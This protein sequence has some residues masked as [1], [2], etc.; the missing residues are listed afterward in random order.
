MR[1][2]PRDGWRALLPLAGVKDG[3]ADDLIALVA[4]DHVV[5]CDLAVGGMTG[6]LE[7]DVEGVRLFV[8]GRPEIAVRR[9]PDDGSELQ[10]LLRVY[11]GRSIMAIAASDRFELKCLRI[12][13]RR[14]FG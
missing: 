7:A 1:A 12:Q 4:D 6:F 5:V 11:H 2:Q 14:A 9:V 10:I 13:V 3:E 8:I